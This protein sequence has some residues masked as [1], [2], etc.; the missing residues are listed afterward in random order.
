[1]NTQQQSDIPEV[2]SFQGP[3]WQQVLLRPGLELLIGDHQISQ[4]EKTCFETSSDTC[5][6]CFLLSGSIKSWIQGF[7]E[8][9]KVL[10]LSTGIWLTPRLDAHCEFLPGQDIRHVSVGVR[11]DR[12][13]MADIAGDFL[14]QVLKDFRNILEGRQDRLFCRFGTMTVPMQSATQQIFQC[15][16]KGNMKKLF[17]ESK[18]LEL[19]SHLMTYHFGPQTGPDTLISENDLKSIKKARNFL[20]E[21]METPPSLK[22]LA[23]T[24]GISESRLTR[25]FRKVY[26][27][28]VFGYLR[29]QRMAKARVLLE[30]GNMSVT[31]AAYTVG[32]SSLSHFTRIFHT[33]SGMN[34][35]DFQRGFRQA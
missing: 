31:E 15:P 18:A 22:E 17:L 11:I 13:L 23:R 4:A 14:G 32:Y 35:Q 10:P 26:G 2:R 20:I 29:D 19:I 16:Y 1:M 34:P 8:P 24:V 7:T 33:Y 9:V 28:S 25:N 3:G 21:S 5:E 30:S 27:T 6:L 12:L